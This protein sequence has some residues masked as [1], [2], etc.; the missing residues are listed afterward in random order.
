MSLLSTHLVFRLLS[1]DA[2]CFS[3]FVYFSFPSLLPTSFSASFWDSSFFVFYFSHHDRFSTNRVSKPSIVFL[4]FY[5]SFSTAT[6]TFTTSSFS[7]KVI[8]TCSLA[9]HSSVFAC[10]S[11][12]YSLLWGEWATIMISDSFFCA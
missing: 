10:C 9:V 3:A 6:S 12:L 11:W 8:V 7:R 2:T 1:S 5:T 4:F